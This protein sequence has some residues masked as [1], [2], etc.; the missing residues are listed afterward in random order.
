MNRPPDPSRRRP[1]L[2]I[3]FDDA[4]DVTLG[5]SSGNAAGAGSKAG[6]Q[7]G[8]GEG[9]GGLDHASVVHVRR[10]IGAEN[11]LAK[12]FA[13]QADLPNIQEIFAKE[14]HANLEGG[15][16]A[17]LRP[18]KRRMLIAA[19]IQAGLRPFQT[20]LIMAQVQ[21]ERRHTPEEPHNA[22]AFR[23]GEGA[24]D[25][26]FLGAQLKDQVQS[27]KH[28]FKGET[29]AGDA[30]QGAPGNPS[31]IA[32]ERVIKAAQES[33]VGAKQL[34]FMIVMTILL[35]SGV[36]LGLVMWMG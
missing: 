24:T 23:T 19:G 8:K 35:A 3:A 20:Q 18:S 33:R 26:L 22:D 15:R 16:A 1:L 34:V 9:S 30:R 21:E 25:G 6:H 27:L 36:F 17:I 12:G 14:V 7:S 32:E 29:G 5:E 10:L 28:A 4:K 11:H 13:D 31:N 2:R